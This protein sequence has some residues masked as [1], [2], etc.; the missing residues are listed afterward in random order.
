MM[1]KVRISIFFMFSLCIVLIFSSC[2]TLSLNHS[3]TTPT[4]TITPKQT[5]TPS[6]TQTKTPTQTPTVTP[7]LVGGYPG[8]YI[9]YSSDDEKQT[10]SLFNADGKL[11]KVLL[12]CPFD[13]NKYLLDYS[14]IKWSPTGET[15]AI[16]YYREGG[17]LKLLRPDGTEVFTRNLNIHFYGGYQGQ[18]NWSPDGKWLVFPG[19]GEHT[20]I[21]IY[22]VDINGENLR[23]LT[24]T[25][26][27]DSSPIFLPDGNNIMYYSDGSMGGQIIDKEGENLRF[28][29]YSYSWSPDGLFF[30]SSDIRDRVVKLINNQTGENKVIFST[31][32]NVIPYADVNEIW[33]GERMFSPDGEWILINLYHPSDYIPYDGRDFWHLIDVNNPEK[34]E[35]VGKG[36]VEFSFDGSM[37]MLYGWLPTDGV[38]SDPKYYAISLDGT[39]IIPLSKAAFT[40]FLA[41]WQPH[42]EPDSVFNPEIF[43]ASTPIPKWSSYDNLLVYDSFENGEINLDK[44]QIPDYS[45]LTFFKWKIWD[46]AFNIQSK[47]KNKSQGI[48]FGLPVKKSISEFNAFE[49]KVKLWGGSFGSTDA[50]VQISADLPNKEWSTQCQLIID[51]DKP[52]F[53]CSVTTTIGGTT[54]TEYSTRPII[55]QINNWYTIRIEFSSEFGAIQ[56]YL[57]DRLIST[58]RPE[59]ADLLLQGPLLFPSLGVWD[60]E[61]LI[62]VSF[63]DVKINE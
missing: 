53:V 62:N 55:I 23:Q 50:K 12:E 5:S 61:G 10:W 32:D 37:L 18:I 58:Y 49:S 56:Y 47:G 36:S 17:I 9:V 2:S 63:D 30:L 6:P 21:D 7:T 34:K 60:S 52:Y 59:D 38:I 51:Q 19:D 13:N 27:E 15:V 22:A 29:E 16:L 28:A 57:D 35:F 41:S 11:I 26:A 45:L 42:S 46:E 31:R 44:W 14:E 54:T 3:N 24:N 43:L 33:F 4:Q 8:K 39:K 48:D 25:Y 40:M 20:Y 1:K